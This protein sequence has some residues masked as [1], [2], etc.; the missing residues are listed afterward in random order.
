M[1]IKDIAKNVS[2]IEKDKKVSP[3]PVEPPTVTEEDRTEIEASKT[4]TRQEFSTNIAKVQESTNQAKENSKDG[5][6]NNL[7]DLLNN[8]GCKTKGE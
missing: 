8:L 1:D 6:N 3:E 5:V 7:T 4:D 2:M